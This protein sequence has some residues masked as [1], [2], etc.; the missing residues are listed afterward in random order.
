MHTD[1]SAASRLCLAWVQACVCCSCL[2]YIIIPQ[3]HGL[4]IRLIP[5]AEP[6]VGPTQMGRMMKKD[7]PTVCLESRRRLGLADAL[8]LV[9]GGGCAASGQDR[10]GRRLKGGGPRSAEICHAGPYLFPISNES[11]VCPKRLHHLRPPVWLL[12]W[13]HLYQATLRVRTIKGRSFSCILWQMADSIGK[14]TTSGCRR[15]MDWL[16]LQVHA[17]LYFL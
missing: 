8:G 7:R 4:Q 6:E 13:Y 9:L 5:A 3:L 1:F 16:R 10:S 12:E 15:K 17:A 2:M 14:M 11:Q